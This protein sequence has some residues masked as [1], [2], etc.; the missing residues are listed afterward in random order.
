MFLSSVMLT[1][2]QYLFNLS[3][4]RLC[5]IT[6][7]SLMIAA[8]FKTQREFHFFCQQP[9]TNLSFLLSLS[10]SFFLFSLVL[11]HSLW[12]PPLFAQS[13]FPSP[14]PL[15]S[16]CLP[17]DA[18]QDPWTYLG[19]WVRTPVWSLVQ[20]PTSSWRPNLRHAM[21]PIPD[22]HIDRI[23]LVGRL[24]GWPTHNYISPAQ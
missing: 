5:S 14:H 2:P 13:S 17:R 20:G 1:C 12:I 21:D 23:C 22:R 6:D 3:L 18:A 11:S 10:P 16:I 15:P 4:S 19:P 9:F 8:A 24:C 7:K